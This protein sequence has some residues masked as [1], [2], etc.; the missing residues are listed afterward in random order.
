MRFCHPRICIFSYR[1]RKNRPCPLPV[2]CQ[3]HP[4][5][6]HVTFRVSTLFTHCWFSCFKRIPPKSRELLVL[7]FT[8]AAAHPNFGVLGLHTCE[9][10]EWSEN[11]LRIAHVSISANFP[12]FWQHFPPSYCSSTEVFRV[13]DV[14]YCLTPFA[15]TAKEIHLPLICNTLS[16]QTNKVRAVSCRS[17]SSSLAHT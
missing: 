17:L 7:F 11:Q 16:S 2:R 8:D 4:P 9:P 14:C 10:I 15:T 13:L 12:E 5:Y 3:N 6:D 1:C